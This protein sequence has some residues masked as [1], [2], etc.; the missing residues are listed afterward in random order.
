VRSLD[1]TLVLTAALCHASWN[2]LAKRAAGGKAF[3]FLVFGLETLLYAPAAVVVWLLVRPDLGRPQVAFMAGSAVLHLAYF[4][5]LQLGYR[6]GDLSLVYP[7]ARG[8]GPALS[9]VGAV[10]FLGEHPSGLALAGG[11]LVVL[12]L[13]LLG[14]P[15]AALRSSPRGRHGV[16]FALLTGALIAGYTLWDAHAVKSLGIPPILLDWTS[17]LGRSLLLAPFALRATSLREAWRSQ[18]FEA[19]GVAVLSPLAYILVLTALVSAPVSYV[20]PARELSI[21]FA[22]LMGAF[23]LHERDTARRLPLAGVITAGVVALALG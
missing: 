6:A 11:A 20:A 16:A 22:T 4:L 19:T 9:S 13:V 23:L 21:V 3:V 12:G 2:L 1:L 5:L 7:L 8:T 17:V 14:A 18:R 10:L 15:L